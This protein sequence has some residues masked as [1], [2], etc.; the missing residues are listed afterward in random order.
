MNSH[1]RNTND[2]PFG[3]CFTVY[4]SNWLNYVTATNIPKNCVIITLLWVQLSL[5]EHSRR[6]QKLSENNIK[7][8]YTL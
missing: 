5:R 8:Y 2:L 3:N 4:L 6:F 1:F 7:A